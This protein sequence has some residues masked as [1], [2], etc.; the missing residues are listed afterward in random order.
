[1]DT[2]EINTDSTTIINMI[3]RLVDLL[4]TKEQE[5]KKWYDDIF[6]INSTI[7]AT[8]N[9]YTTKINRLEKKLSRIEKSNK[10]LRK[11]IKNQGS[12]NKS[13]RSQLRRSFRKVL[14]KY[15]K[16]YHI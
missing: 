7:Q 13:I 4:T 1:M 12:I 3:E 5:I 16:K 6:A 10:K 9:E 2:L 8:L 11:K 14:K 15:I